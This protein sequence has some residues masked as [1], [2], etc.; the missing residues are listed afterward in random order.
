MTTI[1]IVTQ[2]FNYPAWR[3]DMERWKIQER[4]YPLYDQE[5]TFD[6][7][8]EQ[9]YN[10]QVIHG[11]ML[12][13][14]NGHGNQ[15][16]PLREKSRARARYENKVFPTQE[17]NPHRL[18]RKIGKKAKS[19]KAKDGAFNYDDMDKGSQC[20]SGMSAE[21]PSVYN[22]RN[23][24]ASLLKEE[25]SDDDNDGDTSNDNS[26]MM[27]FS[28]VDAA[29]EEEMKMEVELSMQD[30]YNVEWGECA[31][32]GARNGDRRKDEEQGLPVKNSSPFC[33]PPRSP[34]RR[35]LKKGKENVS[36]V[37]LEDDDG[38]DD[39]SQDLENGNDHA[40]PEEKYSHRNDND[41]GSF[42]EN[43]IQ[44]LEYGNDHASRRQSYKSKSRSRNNSST[45]H[46]VD[47]SDVESMN[48][49]HF[50]KQ[51]QVVDLATGTRELIV[52]NVKRSTST[53]K[54]QTETIPT[55]SLLVPMVSDDEE[56]DPDLSY[57]SAMEDHVGSNAIMNYLENGEKRTNLN[58]YQPS[59]KNTDS[60]RFGSAGALTESEDEGTEDDDV[61][62]PSDKHTST[63]KI[64]TE[65][66]PTQSLLVPMVS[67]DEEEDPDLSYA[68]AM[69]DHVGSNAIMNYLENGEKRTNLNHYQPSSKNTDSLRFGSAG[70]LTESEDEGTEDDDVVSPSDKHLA[71][72]LA[73]FIDADGKYQSLN[74][75]IASEK[76]S[77]W[78][79]V[80]DDYGEDEP[81]QRL[82]QSRSEDF[83]NEKDHV[84]MMKTLRQR[85][86]EV[87]KSSTG[88]DVS[89]ITRRKNSSVD[90]HTSSTGTR[91]GFVSHVVVSDNE[92][93]VGS[94]GEK[95]TV[96]HL[97]PDEVEV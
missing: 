92:D 27:I 5:D 97:Y 78:H 24:L 32:N 66:I 36:Y 15:N 94:L 35:R 8:E 55:Q 50:G 6:I 57:A 20:L 38:D 84:E 69:E 54:I 40:Y 21:T 10:M 63:L 71:T 30:V 60:L 23:G 46:D 56:E 58:H 16:S 86:P 12:R 31:R 39:E 1:T 44:D 89:P 13:N 90:Q 96:R 61:V 76:S 88:M 72:L 4:E 82:I 17:L 67:D 77:E 34:P 64:Q 22:N 62:S 9:N 53:L 51:L 47:M 29:D 2:C 52:E 68:S 80:L 3:E 65:T 70:A 28:D 81:R 19:T 7:E 18:L 93:E 79:D 91:T 74:E 43:E 59:S 87:F 73:K 48:S 11:Q 83:D 95:G 75:D 25:A 37:G 85:R 14:G 41:S 49:S 33:S 42:H 26:Q 45:F